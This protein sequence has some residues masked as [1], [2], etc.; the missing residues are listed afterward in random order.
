MPEIAPEFIR[1]MTKRHPS[2]RTSAYVWLVTFGIRRMRSV[3]SVLRSTVVPERQKKEH[4]LAPKDCSGRE[5]AA[6]ASL[7]APS[8]AF[9]TFT[10]EKTQVQVTRKPGLADA[11]RI[12]FGAA[13]SVDAST[14]APVSPMLTPPENLSVKPPALASKEPHGTLTRRNAK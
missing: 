2:G 1:Q 11:P 14:T 7:P 12:T 9:A 8:T 6:L 5:A 13:T 3:N 10:K 4:A